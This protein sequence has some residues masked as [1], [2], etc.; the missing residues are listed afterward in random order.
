VHDGA[1]W[2]NDLPG[3]GVDIDEAKAARCPYPEEAGNGN[4]PEIRRL[5][6]TVVKP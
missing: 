2:A 3:W 5:D 4:W 1:M 6:G